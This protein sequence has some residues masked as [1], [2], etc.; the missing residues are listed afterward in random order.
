MSLIAEL[1]RR[2]VFRVGAAYAIVGWLLIEVASVIFP[3]LHLP[4]WTLTFLIVLVVAGFPLALIFAWAFELTPEGIK[5]ESA[6]DRTESGTHV[7]GRKLNFAIIGLLVIAVVYFA[8]DKFVLEQAEVAT[9]SVPAAEAVAREKPIRSLAVLPLG[10]LSGDPEQEYFSDGMTEA[11]IAELGKVRALRVISRQSVMRYKGTDKSMPQIA[12]E[13]DVDAVIEGSVLHSEGRVRI[14]AQLIGTSPERHLWANNYDRDLSDILILSSEVARA[15]AGEIQVTLTPEEEARLGSTRPVNPEAHEAYL[16]GRYY[17]NQFTTEGWNRALDYHKEAIAKDPG[18]ALAYVGLAEAYNLSG[19]WH[20]DRPPQ[21]A[22]R[23]AR[24][25]AEKALE[26]DDTLAEAHSELG[27]AQFVYA[28]DWAGAEREFRSGIQLDPNSAT[29]HDKYAVFLNAM[30]R[31]EEAKTEISRAL[32]LNPLSPIA[33]VDLGV[34]Y[35]RSG[36]YGK[37]RE[38]ASKAAELDPDFSPAYEILGMAFWREGKSEQASEALSKAVQL[39]D[40][41]D[42]IGDLGYVYAASG[43]TEEARKLLRELKQEQAPGHVSVAIAKVHAGL[44]E[45]DLAFASLEEAIEEGNPSVV[46]LNFYPAYDPLRSDPRF[47]ELLRRMNYP[48]S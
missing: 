46:W 6:V 19:S 33:Y 11:L 32:E 25:A 44:G 4:D 2:N 47:A 7:A 26:I 37:A 15:I 9:E 39:H 16:K 31:F 13:L 8:V 10:N 27:F 30:G 24:A 3:G 42:R 28:W 41:P 35:L 21:E 5:R 22:Y 45:N 43:R 23:L 12:Q 29:T 18:F 40:H 34:N 36:Q 14:T 1:K 17:W 48:G 20:G 38:Q